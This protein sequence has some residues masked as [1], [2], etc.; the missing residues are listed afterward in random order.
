LIDRSSVSLAQLPNPDE[1]SLGVLSRSSEEVNL[2][3]STYQTYPD[4]NSWIRS[5]KKNTHLPKSISTWHALPC[6]SKLGY[7]IVKNLEHRKG[8]LERHVNKI[9]DSDRPTF[10]AASLDKWHWLVDIHVCGTMFVIFAAQF[11]PA[12]KTYQYNWKLFLKTYFLRPVA[13]LKTDRIPPHPKWHLVWQCWWIT[14]N[15]ENAT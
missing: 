4:T 13:K 15:T 12:G 2:W 3:S 7:F 6:T 10:A 5:C 14:Y 11:W 8:K 9:S 1:R